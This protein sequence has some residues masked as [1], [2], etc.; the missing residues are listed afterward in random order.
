MSEN[1]AEELAKEQDYPEVIQRL[2]KYYDEFSDV[3]VEQLDDLYHEDVTFIDPIHHVHGL[4]EL[5]SYFKGT[6]EGVEQCH[7]AFTEWAENGDQVFVNWQMRLR[8]PKLAENQE[9]VVPGVSHL[10]FKEDKIIQQRDYY[11]MGA[12]IYEHVTLL[13]YVINKIKSRMVPS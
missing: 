1:K 5:K 7:F 6:M 13:G 3:N 12:M 11:D 10:E 2:R 8:H 4:D 9:I